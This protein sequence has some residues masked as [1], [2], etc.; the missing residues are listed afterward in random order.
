MR[1]SRYEAT[2]EAFCSARSDHLQWQK[3]L[4][5]DFNTL[6]LASDGQRPLKTDLH[7]LVHASDVQRGQK[8]AL[9]PSASA[10]GEQRRFRRDLDAVVQGVGRGKK[11][12]GKPSKEQRYHQLPNTRKEKKKDYRELNPSK[13]QGR[14]G[15]LRLPLQQKS[16]HSHGKR[17]DS[18]TIKAKLRVVDDDA[19]LRQQ[20]AN[21]SPEDA[22]TCQQQTDPFTKETKFLPDHSG[23]DQPRIPM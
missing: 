7:S 19:K 22:R 11:G 4:Q 15:Q 17:G 14:E 20:Y 21:A 8:S 9:Q 2:I 5:K 3:R 16:L 18:G 23:A 13:S 12:L 1:L 10:T 6:V